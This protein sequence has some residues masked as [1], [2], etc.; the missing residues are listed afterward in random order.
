M[1]IRRIAIVIAALG[2]IAATGVVA[3]MYVTDRDVREVAREATAP[4]VGGPFSLIDHTGRAVTD[5]DYDGKLKVV[6]FGFTYC[7]DIC[8]TG[9]YKISQALDALSAGVE[10]VQPLFISVDPERDTVEVM[11]D[12]VANFHPSF[13]G[14]TGSLEQI[15]AV[16]KA[17]FVYYA[18]VYPE[19]SEGSD[20]YLVDHSAFTFLMGPSGKFL[21]ALPHG[22]TA[23]EL[24]AKIRTHLDTLKRGEEIS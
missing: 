4:E 2:L 18:K 22:V 1:R 11:A 24:A 5:A 6:Y 15:D 16:A 14:L 13:V 19:G 17:Y 21:E 10:H 9:L 20:D 23:D 12:Y 7:P 8:P 3:A